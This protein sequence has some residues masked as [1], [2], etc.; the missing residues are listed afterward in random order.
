MEM[1]TRMPIPF[2]KW[3]G[4]RYGADALCYMCDNLFHLDKDILCLTSFSF[5]FYVMTKRYITVQSTGIFGNFVSAIF[6]WRTIYIWNNNEETNYRIS[7][8]QMCNQGCHCFNIAFGEWFGVGFDVDF[9]P[10]WGFYPNFHITRLR[11][12]ACL[13]NGVLDRITAT[14]NPLGN[15][16]V[17]VPATNKPISAPHMH[18]SGYW[19]TCF[20]LVH[21]QIN[22]LNIS[23]HFE[24]VVVYQIYWHEHSPKSK[25]LSIWSAWQKLWKMN[26]LTTWPLTI[27]NSKSLYFFI[28]SP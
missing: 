20:I 16:S 25:Y 26:I 7:T 24:N 19:D 21:V 15:H 14:A 9:V 22:W 11:G 27:R 18:C 3:C 8:G 17:D 1:C 2:K 5:L 12:A 23:S 6:E 4:V 13:V 28:P 10:W